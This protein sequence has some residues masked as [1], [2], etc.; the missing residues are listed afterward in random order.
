[1]DVVR[2]VEQ[3]RETIRE[4]RPKGGIVGLVPTMGFLHEG[5][6][7]LIRAAHAR[8][9][10]VVVSVFVNPTQFNDSADLAAYP[11]DESHDVAVAA[12]AGAT[13]VFA[14]EVTD[15]YPKGFCTTVHIDGPIT[16]TLEGTSRGPQHFFGVATVVAKLFGMVGPDVAFFGQKDAQQC[17]VV[18]R[19]TRDLDLPVEIVTCPTVREP[20]GLAMSS[21]NVRLSADDRRS[22]LALVRGLEAAATCVRRGQRSAATVVA[23]ASQVMADHGVEPEYIA[24]LDPD[25]FAALTEVD[26]RAVVAVAAR[27]GPVRLIDNIVIDPDR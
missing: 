7:S 9:D 4:H 3:L 17:V 18:R 25:T 27:V 8:C 6:A 13:V 2:T 11:R 12:A 23:A 22:A 19:L 10:V 21:R 16:D 1:M 15:V 24:V 26:R 5:H 14:P 20:D